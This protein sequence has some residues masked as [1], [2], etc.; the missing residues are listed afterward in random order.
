MTAAPRKRLP[1]A[2]RRQVR[3]LY[4]GGVAEASRELISDSH[5]D[6]ATGHHPPPLVQGRYL[7]VVGDAAGYAH[8]FCAVGGTE[9]DRYCGVAQRHTNTAALETQKHCG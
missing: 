7:G 9:L 1:T 3:R 6:P 8:I 5:V 2:G 4:T